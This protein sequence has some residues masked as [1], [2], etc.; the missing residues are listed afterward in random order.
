[1]EFLKFEINSCKDCY[2][3]LRNCPTKAIKFVDDKAIIVQENCVLC[4][5]CVNVCP[6]NA[7]RVK[8]DID[9]VKELIK[10]YPNKVALSVAPSFIANFDVKSFKAFKEACMKLGFA[11]VEETAVGAYYVTREYHKII[12]SGKCNGL[13]TTCCPAAVKYVSQHYHEAVK[14]LAPV[15]SPM[16]AHGKIIK[17]DLGDD[18]HVVFVG[19]CIAKKE[20]AYE[21]GIIDYALTFEEL[22]KMFKEKNIAFSDEEEYSEEVNLAR[23]YPITRGIIKSFVDADTDPLEALPIDGVDDINDILSDVTNL[24][25]AF[26]E[27]NMCRGGCINGPCTL[28]KN[29]SNKNNTIVRT[30]VKKLKGPAFK[31]K[32]YDDIDFSYEYK[33]IPNPLKTPSEEEIKKILARI[34]IYRKEDEINCGACGYSSCREKA[35]AVY[36]DLADPEF[37]MPYLKN[38]AESISNEIIKHTPNAI[39]TI[40]REGVIVDANESFFD[41]MRTDKRCVGHFYQDYVALPELLDALQT[42]Q[43]VKSIKVYLD[44]SNMFCD[45]SITVVKEHGL[46]F[47]IFKDQTE[48]TLNEEKMKALRKEMI[49]VTDSVINKQMAAVQ[50]IASLLGESTAEAKAAL[51]KFKNSLKED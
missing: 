40:N 38:K 27:M 34:F 39:V 16:V 35:I 1:M 45:V 23:Y 37:C 3:C 25:G 8:E 18:V 43:N 7:K 5:H 21:S 28:S 33:K 31:E 48:V 17:H 2:S 9:S 36:N 15:V 46:A 10:K 49:D 32:D 14:Y 30:Y 51:V 41:Y 42:G 50:E 26:V 11:Y 22:D 4:G 13:I 29:S 19:P 20:E 44:Q 12:T 47:A 6:Q 24:E